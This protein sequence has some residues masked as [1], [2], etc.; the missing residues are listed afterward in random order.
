[1]KS[2]RR[3]F[4]HRIRTHYPDQEA[5]IVLQT[6]SNY[7]RIARDLTFATTSRNPLDKRLDFSAYF[8]AF[9]MTLDALDES[10]EKIR[11]VCLEVVMEYVRPKNKLHHAFKRFVPKLIGTWVGKVLVKQLHKRVSV[12]QN[13]EGFVANIITDKSETFGLGYGVDIVECGICK[14]F[15]KHRFDKYASLLCEVD[16]ITSNLAGLKLIRTGTIANGAK[17]CDFRYQEIT[18]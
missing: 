6:D 13:K 18:D 17:K 3:Y 10:F 4:L 8:L 5:D 11:L 1:M 2:F 15:K 16:E 7:L 14:L 9:I 12:N